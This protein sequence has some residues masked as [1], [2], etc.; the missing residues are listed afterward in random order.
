M[1]LGSWLHDIVISEINLQ[2]GTS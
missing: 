2:D 1:N